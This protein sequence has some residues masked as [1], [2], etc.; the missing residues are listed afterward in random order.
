MELGAAGLQEQPFRTHGRP[1]VTVPYDAAR[2]VLD[3][4]AETYQHRQ[5]LGLLQGPS[6][7]GK[8]T[9]V[10]H[11]AEELGDEI[12]VAVIDSGTRNARA[13][14]AGILDEFG[15]HLEFNTINELANMVRV[16]AMQQAAS[17]RP[18][19]LVIENVHEMHPEAFR[20]VCDLSKLRVRG[21]NAIRIVLSSN[22]SLEPVLNVPGAKGLVD[23]LTSEA[24]LWSMTLDE[25]IDY[26]HAKLRA[27]GSLNPE[28]IIADDVCEQLHRASGGWPGIVDRLALLALAK[29]ESCPIG[30]ELVEQAALPD[31][32]WMTSEP[33]RVANVRSGDSSNETVPRL[34]VTHNGHTLREVVFDAPR[35]IVGRSEHNDLCINSRHISRHHALLIRKGAATFLMDLNSTNGTFVNSRRVSNHVMAHDDV[36]TIGNHRIKFVHPAADRSVELGPGFDDTV[37][38]QHLGDLRRILARENTE[39]VPLDASAV[40][41]ANE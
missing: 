3:F 33:A 15:Y 7:A 22:S 6:L 17:G 5:G 13:L 10:R 9:L 14:L 20:V 8:T 24:M 25:T 4:L 37:V 2:V 36:V 21:Q 11:F 28:W 29:A 23:R 18:P 38:M 1:L 16:V 26:L 32:D 34:F 41:T 40:K 30:P 35:L 12:A 19:L 27:G 31:C 39:T